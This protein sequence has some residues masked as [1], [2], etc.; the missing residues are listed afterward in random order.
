MPTVSRNAAQH[1]ACAPAFWQQRSSTIDTSHR[2]CSELQCTCHRLQATGHRLGLSCFSSITFIFVP[3]ASQLSSLPTHSPLSSSWCTGLYPYDPCELR[4]SFPNRIVHL[5]T[6]PRTCQSFRCSRTVHLAHPH[7]HPPPNAV[8]KIPLSQHGASQK[9][10][11]A[12]WKHRPSRG[13]RQVT[14]ELHLL[15][16]WG[17]ICFLQPTKVY[18]RLDKCR[19]RLLKIT[20]ARRI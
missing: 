10:H 11:L 9:Y 2:T 3:L 5:S 17:C 19:Q 7:R 1:Q 20:W 8:I 6:Q 12:I 15:I 13:A 4:E 14:S 16:V 18:P